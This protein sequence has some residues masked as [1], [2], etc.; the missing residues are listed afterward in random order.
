MN[1]NN[2]ETVLN[3][4]EQLRRKQQLTQAELATNVGVTR[5]TIIAIEKGDY[6][7]SVLLAIK[8]AHYFKQPVEKVF[9]V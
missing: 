9:Y 4:V 1:R 2:S 7:P 5:Q 3:T 6:V 8:L